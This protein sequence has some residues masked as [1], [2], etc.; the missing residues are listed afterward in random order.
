MSELRTTHG[1]LQLIW[2]SRLTDEGGDSKEKRHRNLKKREVKL[3]RENGFKSSVELKVVTKVDLGAQEGVVGVNDVEEGTGA[4]VGSDYR[5]LRPDV[6]TLLGLRITASVLCLAPFSVLAVDR[7]KGW[8][9]T[10]P[11][12][13]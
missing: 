5:R 9:W 6:S 3:K 13:I 4:A 10:H 12:A 7:E 2:F 1:D 11:W 8:L